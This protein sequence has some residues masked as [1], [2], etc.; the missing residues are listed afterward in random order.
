MQS[1]SG[2]GKLNGSERFP[3]QRETLE[4]DCN[5]DMPL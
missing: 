5:Q 4:V 2:P 1:P 3:C